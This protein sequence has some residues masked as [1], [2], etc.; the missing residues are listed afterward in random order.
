MCTWF[1]EAIVLSISVDEVTF[2]LNELF[3]GTSNAKSGV[4]SSVDD[5]D[6][7]SPSIYILPPEDS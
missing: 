4:D 2:I 5:V 6:T 1:W 3:T 7:F